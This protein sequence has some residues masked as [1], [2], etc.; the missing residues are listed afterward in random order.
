VTGAVGAG[1]INSDSDL[2]A[3]VTIVNDD[4]NDS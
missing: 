4:I 1:T 2:S 3:V